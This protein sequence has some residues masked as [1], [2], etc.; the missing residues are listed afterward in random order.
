MLNQ[1]SEQLAC[2]PLVQISDYYL[3]NFYRQ[4]QYNVK[5]KGDKNKENHHTTKPVQS[6]QGPLSHNSHLLPFE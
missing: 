2:D 6:T 4:W 5:K 3:T 1:T